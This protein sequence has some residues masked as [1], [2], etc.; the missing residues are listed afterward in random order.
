MVHGE[1]TP[2]SALTEKLKSQGLQEVYYPEL[3]SSVELKC[4]CEIAKHAEGDVLPEAI[5]C[6]MQLFVYTLLAIA[7]Q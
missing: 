1:Q 3:H 4:R 7:A 5:P 2:A 6:F